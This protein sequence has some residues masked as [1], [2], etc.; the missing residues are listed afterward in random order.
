MIPNGAGGRGSQRAEVQKWNRWD[1]T[2]HNVT[3]AKAGWL[4]IKRHNEQRIFEKKLAKLFDMG[5]IDE[6][7]DPIKRPAD[8][9]N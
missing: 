7:G 4:S 1:V 2:Q 3:R 8:D 9:L 6:Y 5:I